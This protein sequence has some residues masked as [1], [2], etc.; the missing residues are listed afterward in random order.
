MSTSDIPKASELMPQLVKLDATEVGQLSLFVSSEKWREAY[1]Q[2]LG[3]AGLDAREKAEQLKSGFGKGSVEVVELAEV[4]LASAPM[5]FMK[6]M[7]SDMAAEAAP[8]IEAGKQKVQVK[9]QGK[10]KFKP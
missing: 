10:F 1:L 9:V 6:A 3:Q 2:C 5:P 4:A 7:R 8:G